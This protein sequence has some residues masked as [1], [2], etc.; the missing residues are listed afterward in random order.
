[1]ILK[2][3]QRLY[4]NELDVLYGREEVDTFFSYLLEE[5]CGL[6]LFTLALTPDLTVDKEKESLF[7]KALS[8]LKLEKPIQQILGKTFFCELTIKINEHVLIPRPET[9]ELILWIQEKYEKKQAPLKILDIGTGSGCIAIALAKHFKSAK[10]HAMDISDEALKLAKENAS[11]NDVY[12][13]FLK[14]DILT[15]ESSHNEYD[16]IVSNP[17]YVRVSEKEQIK[18][19]VL[20]YEPHLALFV[21]DDDPLLFYKK[22]A[23]FAVDNLVRNGELFFEINQYLSSSM[24]TLLEK[25]KFSEIELK[26]DV[27]ENP[28]M[29]RAVKNF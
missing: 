12:I 29:I 5:Y 25:N 6:K 19:N 21:T 16:L 10:V 3:I 15:L 8:E 1:M 27:F 9:E 28:R 26:N 24:I 18:N 17:P 7:F 22:I 11:L 13:E 20:Q 23:N 4:H 14:A 2:E